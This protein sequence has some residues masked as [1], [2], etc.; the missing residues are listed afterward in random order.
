METDKVEITVAEPQLR[1]R[2]RHPRRRLGRRNPRQPQRP[3]LRRP[4]A[5]DRPHVQRA[6]PPRSQPRP[7]RLALPLQ[8]LPQDDGRV[9]E[10][11][12]KLR[13]AVA[14][15]VNSDLPLRAEAPCQDHDTASR[16]PPV[17]AHLQSFH[18][19]IN[20]RAENTFAEIWMLDQTCRA[21]EAAKVPQRPRNTLRLT[22]SI[23][24]AASDLRRGKRR[25]VRTG[26]VAQT[27]LPA[28]GQGRAICRRTS[29]TTNNEASWA[30][31]GT[32]IGVPSGA[33]R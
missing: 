12:S 15:L 28:N 22:A 2:P 27:T 13:G 9:E 7:A 14:I 6:V 4:Q 3:D 23:R 33:D 8:G 25:S 32:Q 21:I 31:V 24:M 20:P 29:V 17:P 11:K 5:Q 19:L 10:V 16:M 1:R 18:P 26:R 30:I